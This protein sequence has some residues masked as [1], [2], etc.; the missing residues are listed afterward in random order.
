MSAWKCAISFY[1]LFIT[2]IEQLSQGAGSKRKQE[3]LNRITE[4]YD[5]LLASYQN[6]VTYFRYEKKYKKVLK[7]QW[8]TYFAQTV[9]I[10]ASKHFARLL[11]RKSNYLHANSFS[12][13]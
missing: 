6:R 11:P 5:M 10:R 3:N 4:S 1:S 13:P 7:V 9:Q 8:S 12:R 2:R